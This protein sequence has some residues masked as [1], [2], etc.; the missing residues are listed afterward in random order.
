MANS[1]TKDPMRELDR[2]LLER[3]RLA[4]ATL[5]YQEQ[6]ARYRAAYATLLEAISEAEQGNDSRLRV[7]LD[8]RI[9]PTTTPIHSSPL[10]PSTLDSHGTVSNLMVATTVELAP[11]QPGYTQSPE[12]PDLTHHRNDR[13]HERIASPP[14]PGGLF[15]TFDAAA[16]YPWKTSTT[17]SPWAVMELAAKERLL[18]WSPPNANSPAAK[19]D[20]A[21]DPRN[22][23]SKTLHRES[24]AKPNPK[25]KRRRIASPDIWVSILV[26]G[27]LLVLFS[28]W[29][30]AVTRPSAVLSISAS[31]IETDDVILETPLE[32]PTS[33]DAMESTS[34]PTPEWTPPSE[35]VQNPQVASSLEKLAVGP[36]PMTAETLASSMFGQSQ[37]AMSAGTKLL[38]GAEFFGSKA[39]G[40]T[41]VYVVDSSPSM[42]RDK[43]FEAAKDQ[44]IRSLSSMKPKQRF[45]ISFFGGELESMTFRGQDAETRPIPA[46]PENLSK[47]M[48]WIGQVRIQKDGR[49]PIDALQAAIAMQPDGIFLLFDGDTKVDD[50]TAKVRE[51]NRSK[52][53]LSDGGPKVPIH[54][55]HFFRDEF[56][57]S[58]RTLASENEGTYRFIPRPQ[59]SPFQKPTP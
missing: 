24:L 52:D 58:M 28:F 13:S 56:E 21:P 7:W 16:G 4:L 54:V 57:K 8:Q 39:V 15:G 46:N 3:G 49:P 32:S 14:L 55:I 30:I 34:I 17:S 12:S 1:P 2:G 9:A 44:I 59:K 29:V 51:M 45:H 40:N 48:E 18:H 6:A 23:P 11:K 25:T 50:W 37:S 36:P 38:Q 5:Q 41:F 47:T 20:R 19:T 33:L 42:R 10:D 43:A 53:F 35:L 22:R 27:C 26:H 31:S